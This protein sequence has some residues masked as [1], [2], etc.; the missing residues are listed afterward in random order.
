MASAI[1]TTDM[2]FLRHIKHAYPLP[3]CQVLPLTCKPLDIA[4]LSDSSRS[5][6]GVTSAETK[7]VSVEVV[8]CCVAVWWGM[9]IYYI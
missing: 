8:A 7:T 4:V 3:T 6:K 1:V 5:R 2:A 9:I